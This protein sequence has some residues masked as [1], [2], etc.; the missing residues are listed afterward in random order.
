MPR[1][2]LV[3]P[4][5]LLYKTLSETQSQHYQ[6]TAALHSISELGDTMGGGNFQHHLSSPLSLLLSSPPAAATRGH[7]LTR[8]PPSYYRY[9]TQHITGSFREAAEVQINSF[10]GFTF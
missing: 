6:W 9:H 5:P 4:L 1:L 7:P 10:Y 3:S 8:H 2:W